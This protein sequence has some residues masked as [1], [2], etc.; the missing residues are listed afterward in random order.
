MTALRSFVY[1][2]AMKNKLIYLLNIVVLFFVFAC[3]YLVVDSYIR[4]FQYA[5]FEIQSF[6]VSQEIL[7]KLLLRIVMTIIALT[8]GFA[9]VG[10]FFFSYASR[11]FLMYSLLFF[12]S[13]GWIA[14]TWDRTVMFL[15]GGQISRIWNVSADIFLILYIAVLF[16]LATKSNRANSVFPLH[17]FRA[18]LLLFCIFLIT[19]LKT[20]NGNILTRG[21]SMYYCA[22]SFS[23]LIFSITRCKRLSPINMLMLFT[24]C[25]EGVITSFGKFDT[26]GD[27]HMVY[28]NILPILMISTNLLFFLNFYQIHRTGLLFGRESNRKL[29]ELMVHKEKIADMMIEHC[30]RPVEL[31]KVTLE[32]INCSDSSAKTEEMIQDVYRYANA[33]DR[34]MKNIHEYSVIHA[35][36]LEEYSVKMHLMTIIRNAFDSLQ[37]NQ[38]TWNC[39]QD[40]DC[41][42]L[43]ICGDPFK[44]IDVN[45][46]LLS[47]LYNYKGSHA[48]RMRVD[49]DETCVHV[50]FQLQI[51]K[52]KR[53]RISSITRRAAKKNFVSSIVEEEL[54][55]L[56]IVKQF[57]EMNRGKITLNLH[58]DILETVY[59]LPLGSSKTDVTHSLNRYGVDNA[60][61]TIALISALPQQIELVHKYLMN[62]NIDMKLFSS[63][64]DALQYIR[65]DKKLNMVIIGDIF[66]KMDAIQLC[67]KI[68]NVFSLEQLPVLLIT[69]GRHIS[70][71]TDTLQLAND[72]MFAPLEYHAFLQ[73]IHSLIILQESVE[74]SRLS[75]LDFLQAQM[76]PHFIFNTI[77]TIMPLLLEE[78]E[79]AYDMLGY[80]SEYLRGN[81]FHK[82]LSTPVLLEQELELIDAYLYIQNVRFNHTIY[83]TI[84]NSAGDNIYILPLILEPII[85]NS[86]KHGKAK[87]KELHIELSIRETEYGIEFCICDDGN[88]IN[89][90]RLR[91]ILTDDND[92]GS[93]GLSNL[94]KRLQI[95]Y[96]AL[97]NI[98]SSLGKGTCI[99]FAISWDRLEM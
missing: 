45:M 23:S 58:R 31:L 47:F 50:S 93:I 18:V 37:E 68:R 7:K 87:D 42:E 32:T 43:E 90:E 40:C 36:Y 30:Q 14:T 83:Y 35:E 89:P 81:L 80:F 88:G 95:Y 46:K 24:C 4:A 12:V 84:H 69:N 60:P 11:E 91:E 41:D 94:R 1:N 73:K 17:K 44:L 34:S 5:L 16:Y 10:L 79:Q 92:S 62:E 57:I 71:S 13:S 53:H 75:K 82:G 65:N 74:K 54:I 55:P 8:A 76:D 39:E 6:L 38:I 3:I 61:Y 63:G 66:G 70:H 72:V 26:S 96:R 59:V 49:H 78:P 48:L 33:I 86:V 29:H 21:I 15:S 64:I 9:S 99:H 98:E 51:N 19:I 28:I 97:M 22:L 56:S 77:S 2:K 27:I 52:Q 20:V 25:A 67:M 85:E